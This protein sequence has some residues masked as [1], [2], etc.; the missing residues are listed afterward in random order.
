ML[1]ELSFRFQAQEHAAD[2]YYQLI[3]LRKYFTLLRENVND[4]QRENFL[5]Q[6]ADEHYRF[7]SIEFL[8]FRKFLLV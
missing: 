1:F 3:L 4:E 7:V 5:E 2:R 6:R 8:Q